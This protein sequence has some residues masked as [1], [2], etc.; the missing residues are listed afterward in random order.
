MDF[1]KFKQK[2]QELKT[3]AVDLTQKTIEKTATKVSQSSLVLKNEEELK[4]FIAK[5]ENK[6]FTTQEWVEKTF[7]KRVFL[8]AWDSK[9][10]FFKE[11]LVYLPVFLTKAFS[12][13]VSF[14]VVDIQNTQIDL[15]QYEIPEF[16]ALLVFENKELYKLILWEENVK[17]V[18]KSLSLDIN[19]TVEE[20]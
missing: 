1:S 15:W 5:S 4:D 7:T 9:K 6:T 20:M 11:F 12:Q 8:V 19:K 18:V 2:A 16:P 17:K 14:K 3:K 13:N 10:E